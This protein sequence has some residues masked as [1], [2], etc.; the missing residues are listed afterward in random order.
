MVLTGADVVHFGGRLMAAVVGTGRR[1]A[2]AAVPALLA[3]VIAA[4]DELIQPTFEHGDALRAEFAREIASASTPFTIENTI[5]RGSGAAVLLAET[6]GAVRLTNCLKLG[7]GACLTL[8]RKAT[9]RPI[10]I[11]LTR[12]TLRDSGPL[13]RFGGAFAEQAAA[14]QIKIV[15]TD[16]VFA[17]SPLSASSLAASLIE[18][19]STRPRSSL[20][21]SVR[22]QGRDSIVPPGLELLVVTNPQRGTSIPVAN[23]DEQFES[24]LASELEFA[25]PA[26]GANA[27]SRLTHLAVPRSSQHEPL[28]GIDPPALP[29][30]SHEPLEP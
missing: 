20:A 21:Q 2:L 10:T 14:P 13:L 12:V 4:V 29:H 8:G 11:E 27:D 16:S 9:A 17:L 30:F 1:Q 22:W 5:F 23:A 6:P 25:G 28:P 19:Q 15:A 3:T 7:S 24:L 26:S 18:I